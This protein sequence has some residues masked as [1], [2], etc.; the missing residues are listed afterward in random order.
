MIKVYYDGL[1]GYCA[2]EINYYRR[3]APVGIFTWID[4][5]TDANALIDYNITQSEALLY[6]HVI[7]QTDKI[8]I[9]SDAFAI[10][11]KNLPNWKALGHIIS[12][13]IIKFLVKYVY[14]WFAKRRFSKY[15]HCQLAAT[16]L[17]DIQKT[18]LKL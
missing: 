10:I 4:V 8:Y 11:W 14:I 2:K 15:R 18:S 7:D 1:C 13:P 16:K 3:I 12:F 9:G 5:A 6:L 17:P